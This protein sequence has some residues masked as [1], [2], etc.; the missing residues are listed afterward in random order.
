MRKLLLLVISLLIVPG[1][2]YLLV[3]VLLWAIDGRMVPI[4]KELKAGAITFA[5]A[6]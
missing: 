1:G 6:Y 4:G 5:K 3:T 2:L